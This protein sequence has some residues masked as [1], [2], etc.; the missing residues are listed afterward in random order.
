ML[1][2]DGEA[3][4]E[5]IE[6]E[7]GV[8]VEVEKEK[9]WDDEVVDVWSPVCNGI[10]SC[11]TKPLTICVRGEDVIGLP[12]LVCCPAEGGTVAR[13]LMVVPLVLMGWGM[14]GGKVGRVMTT[15]A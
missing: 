14:R 11:P 8:A 5:E 1:A 7:E 3:V 15:L 6:E 10:K 12:W 4:E 9:E 13:R 2:E